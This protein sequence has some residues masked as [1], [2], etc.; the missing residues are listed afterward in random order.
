LP[1]CGSKWSRAGCVVMTEQLYFSQIYNLFFEYS[2]QWYQ[3]LHFLI[4]I[5]SWIQSYKS[6]KQKFTIDVIFIDISF[7]LQF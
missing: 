2:T 3:L 5:R 7:H 1:L 6:L 4:I